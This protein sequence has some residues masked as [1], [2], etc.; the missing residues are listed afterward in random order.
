A[1]DGAGAFDG[2]VGVG[3]K[4]GAGAAAIVAGA[5][6]IIRGIVAHGEN[7][8]AAQR[9]AVGVEQQVGGAAAAV[10]RDRAGVVDRPLQPQRSVVVDVHGAGVGDGVAAGAVEHA[11]LAADGGDDA[12]PGRFQR[13]AGDE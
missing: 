4:V 1:A 9:R 7:T 5:L 6:D 12:A 13:A 2:V 3:E 10:E 8:T 11:G